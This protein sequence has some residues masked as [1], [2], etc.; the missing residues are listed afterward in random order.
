MQCSIPLSL[1]SPAQ[2]CGTGKTS[3][4]P[5]AVALEE[6]STYKTERMPEGASKFHLPM[7]QHH[8]DCSPFPAPNAEHALRPA[9]PLNGQTRR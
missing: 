2:P 4:S 3:C 8:Y 6:F 1:S 5:V 7:E 9:L